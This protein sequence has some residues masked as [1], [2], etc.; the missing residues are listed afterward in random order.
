MLLSDINDLEFQDEDLS[1]QP[2]TDAIRTYSV[3]DYDECFAYT[4]LLGL[5]GNEKV[6][7]LSKVKLKEH[8]LVITE[9][10]GPVL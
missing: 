2:Y 4:P 7:N 6:E 9:L 5:G 10:M 3:P 8:I 1:W